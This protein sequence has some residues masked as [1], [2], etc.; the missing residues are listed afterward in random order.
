M[1]FAWNMLSVGTINLSATK[2][3]ASLMQCIST[4]ADTNAL[5]K[6]LPNL[7][8]QKVNHQSFKN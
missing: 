2:W 7:I 6:S 4:S 8:Q 3:A 5:S 1:M